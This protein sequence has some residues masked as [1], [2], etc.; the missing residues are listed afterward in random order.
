[1]TRPTD[2][3]LADQLADPTPG[4]SWGVKQLATEYGSIATTAGEDT[5]ELDC[6]DA[7]R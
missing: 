6:E 1:M 5:G 7:K 2:W 3:H 4:D